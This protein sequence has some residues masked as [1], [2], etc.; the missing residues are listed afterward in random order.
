MWIKTISG[1]LLNLSLAE[2]VMYDDEDNYTK[3]WIGD[4]CCVI[5]EGNAM[6]FIQNAII[7]HE[8]YVRMV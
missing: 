2:T 7:K 3:A 5:A 8:N 4:S 1:A 6:L